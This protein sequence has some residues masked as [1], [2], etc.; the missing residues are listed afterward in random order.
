MAQATV[1]VCLQVLK[2]R[3]KSRFDSYSSGTVYGSYP[4]IPFRIIAYT[5]FPTTFLEIAVYL[6]LPARTTTQNDQIWE[7]ERQCHK[8]F[9]SI[10]LSSDGVTSLLDQFDFPTFKRLNEKWICDDRENVWKHVK[11]VF[12][13]RFHWRCRC[14][15]L[16]VLR[17]S[18]AQSEQVQKIKSATQKSE[19]ANVDWRKAWEN[20]GENAAIRFRDWLRKWREISSNQNA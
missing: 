14:R 6:C 17:Y 19:Q 13:R 11:S 8:L 2:E 20:A 7:R 3:N 18:S 15:I 5:V 16:A 10:C 4:I 9:D 1:D 12:Q